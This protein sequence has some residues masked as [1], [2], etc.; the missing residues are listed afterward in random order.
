MDGEA[1]VCGV[2][3]S[4]YDSLLLTPTFLFVNVAS[5]AL[6]FVTA[7]ALLSLTR[8]IL[9]TK[10]DFQLATDTCLAQTANEITESRWNR[11][12]NLRLHR[13]IMKQTLS[14][15]RSRSKPVKNPKLS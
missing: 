5:Y 11:A 8:S 9:K 13:K 15:V 10:Q 7:T 2:D 12:M 4:K 14:S 3:T 1:E 6:D